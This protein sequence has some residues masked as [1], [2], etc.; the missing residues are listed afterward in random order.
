[1][2]EDPFTKEKHQVNARTGQAVTYQPELRRS[3]SAPLI[4][5]YCDLSPQM[6]ITL[7]RV[8]SASHNQIP[9]ANRI[10]DILRDWN[11]PV[12]PASEQG[13]HR[14]GVHYLNADGN[15]ESL[16]KATQIEKAFLEASIEHATKLSKEGLQ[17][18]KLVAQVDKKFILVKMPHDNAEFLEHNEE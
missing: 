3:T 11:N 15:L 6:S 4:G 17:R 18:A 9:A 7:S 12:F 16:M 10:N 8:K 5:R 13:V 1:V 14:I 2:W